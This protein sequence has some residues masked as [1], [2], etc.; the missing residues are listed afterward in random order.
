MS[1]GAAAIASAYPALVDAGSPDAGT[2]GTPEARQRSGA[3]EVWFRFSRHRLA[4]VSVVVL[5][6]LVQKHFVQGKTMGAVR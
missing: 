5:A 6:L 2:P 3:S 4:L 1:E